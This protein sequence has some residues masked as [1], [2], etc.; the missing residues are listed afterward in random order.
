MVPLSLREDTPEKQ[1]LWLNPQ[2]AGADYMRP[3]LKSFEP[4]DENMVYW[5]K[6][7]PVR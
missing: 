7:Y 3:Y 5:I 2:P 6:I 1:A 4:E